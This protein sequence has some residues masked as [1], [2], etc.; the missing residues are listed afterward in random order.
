MNAPK[1]DMGRVQTRIIHTEWSTLRIL[2]LWQEL[3]RTPSGAF[4]IGTQ[5]K[6]R[7]TINLLVK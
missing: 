5:M 6:R 1:A 7:Y 2:D 4:I 3:R